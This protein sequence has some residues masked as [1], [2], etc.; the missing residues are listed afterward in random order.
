MPFFSTPHQPPVKLSS[1]LMALFSSLFYTN[2][3]LLYPLHLPKALYIGH[4]LH[5]PRPSF[6]WPSTAPSF[7]S[8]PFNLPSALFNIIIIIIQNP[9]LFWH[10]TLLPLSSDLSSASSS[11]ST[12]LFFLVFHTAAF[13][14]NLLLSSNSIIQ[15]HHPPQASSLWPSAPLLFSPRPF[16]F[17][18]HYPASSSSS[19]ALFSLAFHTAAFLST[20]I[21]LLDAQTKNTSLDLNSPGHRHA[22]GVNSG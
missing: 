17:P 19:T 8:P 20:S 13:L 14:F 2:A 1:S 9:L 16:I 18:Q 6:L 21:P 15:H 22:L 4:H 3:F 10:S 11:P 12:T 5:L 7:S